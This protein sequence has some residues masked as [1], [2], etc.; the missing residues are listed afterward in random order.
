MSQITLE[1]EYPNSTKRVIKV[2]FNS[3][4]MTIRDIAYQNSTL[5]L[6]KKKHTFFLYK[7]TEL[8][9]CY[10]KLVQCS[11]TIRQSAL[12][13]KKIRL[14]LHIDQTRIDPPEDHTAFKLRSLVSNFTKPRGKNGLQLNGQEKTLTNTKENG[15][16]AKDLSP[17]LNRGGNSIVKKQGGEQGLSKNMSQ[18]KETSNSKVNQSLSN[19]MSLSNINSGLPTLFSDALFS[20]N[21]FE[22]METFPAKVVNPDNS[23]SIRLFSFSQRGDE[24]IQQAYESAGHSF[25]KLLPDKAKLVAY[26]NDQ[27]I[28]I[29]NELSTYPA[30]VY[31]AHDLSMP[32]FYILSDE[33]L[34]DFNRKLSFVP[35][36]KINSGG[37]KKKNIKIQVNTPGD[38]IVTV[39]CNADTK[40][41]EF[42]RLTYDEALNRKR[43]I[44]QKKFASYIFQKLPEKTLLNDD[45]KPFSAWGSFLLQKSKQDRKLA[46]FQMVLYVDPQMAKKEKIHKYQIGV[47]LG[48]PLSWT[49]SADEPLFMRHEMSTI[50]NGVKKKID[51]NSLLARLN[52]RLTHAPLPKE[53]Q[54][55]KPFT[56]HLPDGETKKTLRCDVNLT[57]PQSIKIFFEK[58]HWTLPKDS[59]PE[60]FILKITGS[61]EYFD[62]EHP[63]HQFE[64]VRKSLHNNEFV[65]VTL[66][67]KSEILKEKSEDPPEIIGEQ[68]YVHLKPFTHDNLTMEEHDP[69]NE[70]LISLWDIKKQ[71]CFKIIGVQNLQDTADVTLNDSTGIFVKAG[72]YHGGL[73][74][75]REVFTQDLL[76][77]ANLR[78]NQWLKTEIT[79]DHLPRASRLCITVFARSKEGDIP[80]GYVNC[81]LFDYL[82]QLRTQVLSFNLWP[83]EESN[84]IAPCVSNL[85]TNNPMTIYIELESFNYTVL[86]PAFKKL[87]IKNQLNTE[88]Q[89]YEKKRLE[90]VIKKDPLY[91]LTDFDKRAIYKHRYHIMN[92]P[93][94]LPK[95]L[96]SINWANRFQVREAKTLLEMW[97]PMDPVDA[98]ELLDSR[99]SDA[100]VREY[101]V[102]CL[103]E[104]DD[105]QLED[106]LLQ[107]V[108]VLKYEPYHN[109]SLA[110]YLL[111]RALMSP[112]RIGSTFFWSLK[113]ELHVA[114]I[115]ER[116][117]LLIEGYLWG[118]GVNRTVLGKET[119]AFQQITNIANSIKKIKDHEERLQ[120]LRSKLT[121]LQLPSDLIVPLNSTWV[122]N[123]F[124][125][126]K[127]KFMD[128]KKV[129]LWLVMTKPDVQNET[130]SVLF[131][132]GDDLRQDILTLQMIGIMD[133]LWKQEGLDLRLNPYKVIATGDE[134][135][136]LEVVLKSETVAKVQGQ[137]GGGATAAF[138][139]T[140]MVNWLAKMNN[141]EEK[142]KY[143]VENFIYSTAGY[144]VA[145][146]VLGIGDRH[147]DNVMIQKDGHLFHIDFGHFLGNYKK[148]FGFKRER[149]PF[150][151]T[152]A[153]AAVM[154]G[155]GA[156]DYK[157]FVDISC[158]AYNIIRKKA[159]VF[160]NLF[161]LM[162][163]TGIPELQKMSD[164]YYLRDAFML[165]LDDEKAAEEFA[166]LIDQS[167]GT[168]TTRVNDFFH[169]AKHGT[170]K[171]K[172]KKK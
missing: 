131:K 110:K 145:T 43:P 67:Y 104:F 143:A 101:A 170:K 30:I 146:Y 98:L 11:R 48:K 122:V 29:V 2:P 47:V 113:S 134:V 75:C 51:P 35:T 99:F 84:P 107:L 57:S 95:F 37:K 91:K 72:V 89:D 64:A 169:L 78:W 27:V 54:M 40:L 103:D 80:L 31:K 87:E 100:S 117:S 14:K 9:T 108:Q 83:A 166:K 135:G 111:K 132:S 10:S 160:I 149:A 139:T 136:M 114:E 39:V 46:H 17:L 77:T 156:K 65:H 13:G 151:F 90:R 36:K 172:K 70:E 7:T 120:D 155:K 97:A 82:S 121:K 26:L 109:S 88:I 128:S 60:D 153:Y 20:M 59:K 1:L 73:P 58:N 69:S 147:S 112:W 106:F 74:M 115:S 16:Q 62:E 165:D 34:E 86:F 124:Q 164:I 19:S 8:P 138:K 12:I 22:D 68:D 61:G 4:L 162:L 5:Q 32:I 33:E 161:A 85:S 158:R 159:D 23:Y 42:K 76:P 41:K 3:T 24:I 126:D 171:E 49:S 6:P 55:Q 56:F 118:C 21:L 50:R 38:I 52:V 129:P 25:L 157:R 123:G 81:Q 148:K 105:E 130:Y 53:S 116:F 28:D 154:G 119:K 45:D 152:P 127:C 71:F 142:M 125:V 168:K 96:L 66:L 167:L 93:K 94:S 79:M 137:A 18:L 102:K 150:V 63:L 15:Y 140:Y 44:V 133:K 141:T 92:D 144:I 163:S